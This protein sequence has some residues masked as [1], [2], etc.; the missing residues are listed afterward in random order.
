MY[1][2]WNQKPTTPSSQLPQLPLPQWGSSGNCDSAMDTTAKGWCHPLWLSSVGDSVILWIP[3]GIDGQYGVQALLDCPPIS[4]SVVVP[5]PQDCAGLGHPTMQTMAVPHNWLHMEPSQP[6]IPRHCARRGDA[7]WTHP[8]VGA[9]A[10]CLCESLHWPCSDDEN[11]PHLWVL[12][13]TPQCTKH[14]T[15]WSH[16]SNP[17]RPWTTA[18]FPDYP[19]NE[20]EQIIPI[21]LHLHWNCCQS[22]QLA[23][24][25]WWMLP[26]SHGS[27]L[28][29][30]Q[31]VVPAPCTPLS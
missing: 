15:T 1:P 31:A 8:T 24:A 26:T 7:V 3:G 19:P 23:L 4:C 29:P 6:Y 18:C 9:S 14:P 20:V 28:R 21:L 17:T 5:T 30:M 2:P 27:R 13:H 10:N 22:L 12:L 11:Q 16:S 25:M